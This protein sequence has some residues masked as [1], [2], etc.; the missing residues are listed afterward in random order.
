MGVGH[1]KGAIAKLSKLGE[2]RKK[3]R[4]I[5]GK[6]ELA[7]RRMVGS[8]SL[9]AAKIKIAKGTGRTTPT[10]TTGG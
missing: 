3:R 2:K 4:N 9:P 7:K 1:E 5:H 8:R 6:N 10:G